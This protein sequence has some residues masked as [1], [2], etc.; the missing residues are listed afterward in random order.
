MPS[1]SCFDKLELNDSAVDL[2]LELTRDNLGQLNRI[3]KSNITA[4]ELTTAGR[5]FAENYDHGLKHSQEVWQKAKTIANSCPNLTWLLTSQIRSMTGEMI[6]RWAALLHDFPR[7]LGFNSL[8]HQYAG[9]VM[10][11]VIF[12]G[13]ADKQLLQTLGHS[14][15]RHDYI[16]R[17]AEFDSLPPELMEPLPEIFRLADKISLPPVEEIVRYYLAGKYSDNTFFNEA[18]ETNNRFDLRGNRTDWDQIQHF[19]LLFSIQKEDFFFAETA[20]VYQKWAR[21]KPRAW[22]KIL[23]LARQDE[24]LPSEKIQKIDDVLRAFHQH[25]QI[26]LIYQLA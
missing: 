22:Q 23:D 10:A 4:S 17:I 16:S 24:G 6:F 11:A 8:K 12:S 21:G 7:F 14:L 5:R 2:L 9:A 13:L 19:L 15:L 1:E 25:F 18:T 20:A 26:P 3:L